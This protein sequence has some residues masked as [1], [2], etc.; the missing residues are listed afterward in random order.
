MTVNQGR[1]HPP[2][3][4]KL[5]VTFTLVALWLWSSEPVWLLASVFKPY[6]S[7]LLL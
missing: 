3:T 6:R 4:A 2:K 7:V 1:P 5:P